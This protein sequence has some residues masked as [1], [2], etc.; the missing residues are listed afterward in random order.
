[1]P[2]GNLELHKRMESSG[3]GKCISEYKIFSQS[4]FDFKDN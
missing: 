4:Q 2:D 1:M 3:T